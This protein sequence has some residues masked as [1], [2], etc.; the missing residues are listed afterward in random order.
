MDD[1]RIQTSAD[2]HERPEPECIERRI[3]AASDDPEEGEQDQGADEVDV[4]LFI[5]KH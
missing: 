2:G 1:E 3:Q 5:S 4:R